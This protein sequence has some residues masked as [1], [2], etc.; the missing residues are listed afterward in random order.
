MLW[1]D[2]YQ[3]RRKWDYIGI[4][5]K[6]FREDVCED[7]TFVNRFDTQESIHEESNRNQTW[8]VGRTRLWRTCLTKF[9]WEANSDFELNTIYY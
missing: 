8:E 3:A 5:K 7:M 4:F 9:Q 1:S 2:D 6:V